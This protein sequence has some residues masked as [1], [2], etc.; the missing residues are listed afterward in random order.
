[1][2]VI[3]HLFKPIERTTRRGKLNINYVLWVI[4]ICCYR[5]INYNKCTALVG[6]VDNG[7]AMHVWEQGV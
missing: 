7:G 5:F 1:M 3:I 2:H 6:D 4:M